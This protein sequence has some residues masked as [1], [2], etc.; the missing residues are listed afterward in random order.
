MKKIVI[1]FLCIIIPLFSLD[2]TALGTRGGFK[3]YSP[4]TEKAGTVSLSVHSDA[5][6]SG[7][8]M[9]IRPYITLSVTPWTYFETSVYG[10][11][12]FD[13]N[14][15]YV[16]DSLKSVG[17][18]LKGSYPFQINA[19]FRVVPGILG[20]VETQN[21]LSQNSIVFGGYG[22]F[23]ISLPYFS[24]SLGGGY[25]TS[26]DPAVEPVI[27]GGTIIEGGIQYIKAIVEANYNHGMNTRTDSIWITPG[28][29]AS[30]GKKFVI[31]LN[32][33]VELNY[34]TFSTYVGYGGLSFAYIFSYEKM[35]FIVK[36]VDKETSQPIPNATVEIYGP[37]T[38]SAI[39]DS[40]GKAYFEVDKG[41]YRVEVT[42]K[43]YLPII[44]EPI[45]VKE[46]QTIDIAR[47]Q[48]IKEARVSG[49]VIDEIDRKPLRGVVE[50]IS[51]D[52]VEAPYPI[53]NDPVTG[54]YTLRMKPSR[55]IL[56]ATVDGYVPLEKHII[57]KE[58]DDIIV[59]FYMKR[60]KKKVIITKLPVIY[61]RRY[62]KVITPEQ[63]PSL[64]IILQFL[65][66]NPDV[67]LEIIGHTDSVG[68]SQDN[69][70]VSIKRANN[71]RNYLIMNGI[72]P[73]RLIVKGFGENMPVG[74]N[75]TKKGRALNRRV[76]F[77]IIK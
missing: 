26:I 4:F 55:Y 3:F 35:E 19:N 70:D 76:E 21:P 66:E 72:T 64:N 18:N 32:A 12:N 36:V 58:G 23:G 40:L 20:F 56:K 69:Y 14:G 77:R 60:A 46:E 68:D 28:I 61:F 27:K 59:D 53:L 38:A 41:K 39:T 50:P 43:N 22:L 52:E 2:Q 63:Y 37:D 17:G 16:P 67:T 11:A 29:R 31:S 24:L 73:Q 15:P 47:M 8:S 75:R 6:P 13:I 7:S 9:I 45:H 1:L 25:T 57:L 10:S 30:L 71:V 44:R 65:K 5:F 51:I 33:G 49:F 48:E 74:D 42:S 54:L 34:P 62:Q